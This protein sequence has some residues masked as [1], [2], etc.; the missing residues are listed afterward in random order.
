VLSCWIIAYEQMK[1]VKSWNKNSLADFEVVLKFWKD[2]N[3]N[4]WL[5]KLFYFNYIMLV[6]EIK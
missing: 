4:M 2:I 3:V 6:F 5:W 1:V